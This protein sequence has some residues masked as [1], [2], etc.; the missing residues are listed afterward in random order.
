MGLEPSSSIILQAQVSELGRLNHWLE[1]L[2]ERER[3]TSQLS[4][5]VDLCLT[6][7]VT[8][9]ISYGYAGEQAPGDSVAVHYY[10]AP[11]ELIF[12][13]LDRGVAFDPTTYVSA[14]LPASLEDAEPGGQGLR[15]VHQ[16]VGSMHY[17]RDAAGNCLELRFPLTVS[18]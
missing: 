18:A 5:R 10:L 3:L 9:V 11:N 1:T 15:L 6:E 7:L 8:N 4:F 12:K 13:I 2:F 16:Y 14:P 17:Q